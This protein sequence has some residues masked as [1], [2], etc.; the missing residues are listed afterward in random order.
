MSEGENATI[1][2]FRENVL[3]SLNEL[4]YSQCRKHREKRIILHFNN[5]L[6]HNAEVVQ[7]NL[8]DVGF[9]RRKHLRSSPDLELSGSSQGEFLRAIES[10]LGELSDEPLA[11]TVG[12]MD[13]PI[14]D[15]L[16]K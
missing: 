3:W 12:G 11:T 16:E 9:I 2:C 5:P 1:A 13:K 10:F 15:M 7:E 4:C 14:A 8:A 6:S